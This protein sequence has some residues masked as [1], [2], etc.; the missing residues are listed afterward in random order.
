[1]AQDGTAKAASASPHGVRSPSLRDSYGGGGS[2]GSTTVEA[3]LRSLGDGNPPAW[4][5]AIEGEPTRLIPPD[6]VESALEDPPAPLPP[7]L[8]K[9]WP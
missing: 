8:D 3:R 4:T 7:F 6:R 2:S 5:A 9:P 1:M